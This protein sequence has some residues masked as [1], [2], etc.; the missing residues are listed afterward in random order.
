[1]TPRQIFDAKLPNLHKVITWRARKYRLPEHEAEEVRQWAALVLWQ[2]CLRGVENIDCQTIA[3]GGWQRWRRTRG[4]P[5]GSLDSCETFAAAER[6]PARDGSITMGGGVAYTLTDARM[7]SP[8]TFT[9]AEGGITAREV[10]K[11]L[12]ITRQAVHL[13]KRALGAVRIGG[14]WV[15]PVDAGR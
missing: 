6:V 1:M 10:A 3:L 13:R 11:R 4:E 2:Q 12:G 9:T 15:F 14:R 5:V 8:E 7:D